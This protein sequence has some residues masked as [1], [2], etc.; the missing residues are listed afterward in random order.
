[1]NN[2][3][4]IS[5]V[6]LLVASAG[7]AMPRPLAAQPHDMTRFLVP[8]YI[9]NAIEGAFGSIWV[10][11]LRIFNGNPV[12]VTVLDVHQPCPFDP[13]TSEVTPIPART[14]AQGSN[15]HG[16]AVRNN[17][18]LL[19]R[20]PAETAANLWFQLYV[21]DT[22]CTHFGLGTWLPVV[23]E[24]QFHDGTLHII[25]VPAG[26]NYRRM[27]RVYSMDPNATVATVR[28]YLDRG[29]WTRTSPPD[30]LLGELTVPLIAGSE[31]Q[32]SYG[33]IADFASGE[34]MVR[35][36]IESEARIWAMVSVTNNATQEV[37]AVLPNPL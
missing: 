37:T 18:G 35:L 26:E 24:D 23:P 4:R 7:L 21:R 10:S 3:R 1:M 15:V 28:T 12:P 36:E 19:L 29:L 33:Q 31:T 9:P 6:L 34:G 20:T 32:P 14:T 11:D 30:P 22:S 17:P 27:L 13:C 25:G 5:A 16:S 8:I 2:L